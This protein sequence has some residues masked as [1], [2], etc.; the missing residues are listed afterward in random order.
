V[1]DQLCFIQFLHPGG[2]HRPPSG[3][4]MPWNEG[5]HKRKFMCSRGSATDSRDTVEDE[6]VF[7]GE[8]E[9]QSRV[10]Q[11]Y[12]DPKPD[13]PRWLQGPFWEPVEP[14]RWVQNTDP[15]VFGE[16]F[17]YTGC[18][19]DRMIGGRRRP[20]QLRHLSQGS[21]ILFGSCRHDR[22]VLDTVF[23][24]ASHVDHGLATRDR[25]LANVVS[26]T[27]RSVV[28]APWYHN[29]PFA[30]QSFRLYSGATPANPVHGMFSFVPSALRSEAPR[31]F[32]RPV[33]ELPEAITDNHKQSFRLNPQ[34]NVEAA[35]RLWR[36]VCE[37]VL[38]SGLVLGTH[39]ALPPRAEAQTVAVS[40]RGA[41]A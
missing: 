24:V 38:R 29:P 11:A 15:F 33:I 26:D 22:F 28:I 41:V 35:A 12:R 31:G 17:H 34:A 25:V 13:H 1:H 36:S 20:T 21:V 3:G 40:S 39:F 32:A 9:P 5:D 16:Q 4:V 37:Q 30:Y 6:L 10:I 19:Q 27:Y 8:W 18:Q 7:W 14:P 23:V 2:E